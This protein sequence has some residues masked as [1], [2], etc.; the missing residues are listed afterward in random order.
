MGQQ[1]NCV[2]HSILV[3]KSYK[4]E[5]QN[6]PALPLAGCNKKFSSKPSPV[7]LKLKM[8]TMR[9][10]LK[11]NTYLLS[12]LHLLCTFTQFYT[13]V[14]KKKCLTCISI[15]MASW[16]FI[17]AWQSDANTKNNNALPNNWQIWNLWVLYKILQTSGRD[18]FSY[19]LM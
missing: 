10:G 12:V 18:F 16:C 2:V 1:L 14:E 9:A 7:L 11:H 8:Y 19:L 17:D 5:L 13:T 6:F 4:R 15:C 3:K